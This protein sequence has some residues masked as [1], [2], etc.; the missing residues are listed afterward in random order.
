MTPGYRDPQERA[1]LRGW[2]DVAEWSGLDL[3][4]Y[5][6]E[7]GCEP[8]LESIRATLDVLDGAS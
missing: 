2:L 3:S 8:T 4:I 1:W 5:A 7:L 6:Y